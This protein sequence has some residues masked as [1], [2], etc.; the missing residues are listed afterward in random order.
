MKKI[1]KAL[2]FTIVFIMFLSV[3]VACDKDFT[4]IESDV[5][6]EQNANFFTSIDTLSI[7]AYNKKLESV[8]TNNLA[9]S[10]LGVFNDAEY[11]KSTASIITQLTPAT[12]TENFDV[13]PVIDSV[14]INI[15]YFST[16]TGTET[17][18]PNAATYTLDSLYGN[19][20]APIKLTIYQNNYFL[21]DFDP[22]GD[23]NT[24]QNHYSI[25][26]NL[27]DPTHNY[28]SNGSQT[29]DFDNHIGQIIYQNNAFKPSLKAKELWEISSTDTLKTYAAPALRISFESDNEDHEDE[30]NFWHQT[31][32]EKDGAAELSNDNEFKDYFRGL[33]FKA[34]AIGDDGSMFL[35]NLESTGAN[36]TIYY[37]KGET[38]ERIQDEYV[39]NFTGNKLNTFINDFNKISLEDGDAENGDQTLHIK[40]LEGAMTVVNLFNG[41]VE[42]EDNAGNISEIPAID[43]FKKTYRK[44]DS[45]G[46]Y[47]MDESGNYVLNRL[48]NEAHLEIFEDQTKV[49]N[50]EDE[51]GDIYHKYD[52]IYAYDIKNGTTTIDYQ[53]D[54]FENNEAFSS[55]IFSLGQRDDS[56]KYKIRLTEHL[57]NIIQNDSTNYQIGLILS[58][59]VNYVVNSKILNSSD[60]VSTIPSA[61]MLSPRG[62]ILY[63]SNENVSIDKRLKLKVFF[64]KPKEN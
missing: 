35:I 64:T 3:F 29:I 59:N 16:T 44:T 2:K 36:I 25:T 21:R 50:T 8:Q 54:P 60:N 26:E 6:G 5:L 19:I 27:D 58:N 49:I 23:A 1:F 7:S 37:T 31:I 24:T 43:Y 18:N 20:D 42:Y 33:Y 22:S 12:F 38:D 62:T 57:N 39:L 4:S 17:D 13:N 10:L 14:V 56:G 47:V 52:R 63:G 15:P 61:S 34:E 40:G 30:I 28:A 11:G 51:N 45:D 48:I 53:I 41:L 46:N 9:S 32:V 55:K